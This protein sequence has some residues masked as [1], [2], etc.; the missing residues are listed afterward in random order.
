M[1]LLC[2]HQ[3]ERLAAAIILQLL[4]QRGVAAVFP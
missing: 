4:Q 2:L 3:P 1:L